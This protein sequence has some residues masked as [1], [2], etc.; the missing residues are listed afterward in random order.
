M[1][2]GVRGGEQHARRHRQGIDE[3]ERRHAGR[4]GGPG[5]LRGASGWRIADLRASRSAAYGAAVLSVLRSLD[6]LRFATHLGYY[7][8]HGFLTGED[9]K[10]AYW[11]QQA[12][13]MHYF[14]VVDPLL[15]LQGQILELQ[16]EI[17]NQDA[18]NHLLYGAIKRTRIIWS[19]Y[20]EIFAI[21]PPDRKSPLKKNETFDLDRALND[22]YIHSIGLLD[23]F[24]WGIL[25][26]L[27]PEKSDVIHPANVGLFSKEYLKL[28]N[29]CGLSEVVSFFKDW[30]RGLK[31]RRNSGAHRIPLSVP[32]SIVTEE[33]AVIRAGLLEAWNKASAKHITALS[34]KKPHEETEKLERIAKNLMDRVENSG[35][36]WCYMVQDPA[37]PP[38]PIYPTISEDL[39]YLVQLV[40]ALI[41]FLKKAS[42]AANPIQNP[43][44]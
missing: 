37:T 13:E 43:H 23:N 11:H 4:G 31:L 41:D 3:A 21:A 14:N 27:H 12:H 44:D 6:D 9:I 26:A 7:K 18:K 15:D 16:Y 30:E 34:Q 40:R 32:P 22:I 38:I 5:D 17:K 29:L 2:K 36:F 35:T 1:D 42:A 10:D 33:E 28:P 8:R 39:G 20:R 19:A 25:Y 24:A